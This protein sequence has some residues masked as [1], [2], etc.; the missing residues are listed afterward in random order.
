MLE[1]H[2]SRIG[3]SASQQPRDIDAQ[4]SRQTILRSF[5]AL[6]VAMVTIET[7]WR[8]ASSGSAHYGDKYLAGGPNAPTLS[9]LLVT[10]ATEQLQPVT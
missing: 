6:R 2:F 1:C 7:R 8:L 5:R 9:R 3:I 4:P 10:V